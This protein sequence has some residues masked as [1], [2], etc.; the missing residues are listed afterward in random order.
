MDPSPEDVMKEDMMELNLER[1]GDEQKRRMKLAHKCNKL[2]LR[3]PTLNLAIGVAFLQVLAD[4][5]PNTKE[6]T[7]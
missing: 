7:E 3:K 4:V 5:D 1:E 2:S 6:L